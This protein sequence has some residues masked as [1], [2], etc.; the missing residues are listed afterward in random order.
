MLIDYSKMDEEWRTNFNYLIIDNEQSQDQEDRKKK[1]TSISCSDIL[2][3]ND[4]FSVFDEILLHN[5]LCGNN[6]SGSSSC[7]PE[8]C[9]LCNRLS[10]KFFDSLD[11]IILPV[12]FS[13]STDLMYQKFEKPN[14]GANLDAHSDYNEDSRHDG[15]EHGGKS[16]MPSSCRRVGDALRKKSQ[17]YLKFLS[18]RKALRKCENCCHSLKTAW[19]SFLD[20][21]CVTFSIWHL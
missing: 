3:A 5:S 18:T 7:H 13:N 12:T 19:K 17:A 2:A 1:R 15:A 16:R 10:S 21:T 8:T 4:F 14:S 9:C 20:S 6:S 11:A